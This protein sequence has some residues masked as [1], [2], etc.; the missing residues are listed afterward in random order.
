[1]KKIA[2]FITA[3]ALFIGFT[4]CVRGYV[5][6][7]DLY[8]KTGAFKTWY[9]Q[10]KDKDTEALIENIDKDTMLVFGSSEFGHQRKSKYHLRNMF[11]KD[12][13]NVMT[14]G[15]AFS[16][17]F[18]HTINLGA[19]APH[20]SNNKVV[21]IISPTWFL[22]TKI[23]RNQFSYRFS[24]TAYIGLL[25][26]NNIPAKLKNR[27]AARVETLLADDSK[28]LKRVKAYNAV[29][30]DN[31]KNPVTL[32]IE[33]KYEDDIKT[34]VRTNLIAAR[35]AYKE[36]TTTQTIASSYT[37]DGAVDFEALL[38]R[39]Y[40]SSLKDSDNPL[41]IPDKMWYK[42]Y[43]KKYDTMVGAHDF[44][45]MDV[46]EEYGDLK[47]FLEICKAENIK[48]LLIIQPLNGYWYDRTGLSSDKRELFNEKIRSISK[49]YGAEV[50]D[51]SYY[52]YVPYVMSDSVHPWK[53]GWVLLNESIYNF[54]HDIKDSDE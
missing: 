27:I 26:N 3:F 11:T 20:I 13:L 52:D 2:A 30:I 33:G 8:D 4:G 37:T 9:N 19:L 25:Q 46:S 38:F 29:Y 5:F 28:K 43:R 22:G 40:K 21:L 32:A 44:D 14:I 17:T 15:E 42:T 36:S 24:D 53:E 35:K 48:P 23:D 41:Y 54:Y 51:L 12:Q 18:I 1:M 45:R 7:N 16:Q 47:L 49:R 31:T 10:Y 34:E 6:S 50:S 39:A